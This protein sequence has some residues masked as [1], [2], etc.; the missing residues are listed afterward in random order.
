M[1]SDGYLALAPLFQGRLHQAS[2][3]RRS[4]CLL[5]WTA[6]EPYQSEIN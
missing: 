5:I 1:S 2:G 3:S 4:E 6:L